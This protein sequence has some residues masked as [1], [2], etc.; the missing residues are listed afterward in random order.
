M[1]TLNIPFEE[2][3]FKEL[4]DKKQEYS[5]K[6]GLPDLSWK[7]FFMLNLGFKLNNSKWEIENEK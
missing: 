6:I 3:E 2:T 4:E 5:E 1:K 7:S